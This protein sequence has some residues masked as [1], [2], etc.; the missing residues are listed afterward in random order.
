MISHNLCIDL[1]KRESKRGEINGE[2][3]QPTVAK[4]PIKEILAAERWERI[5]HLLGHVSD[6]QKTVLLL[7]FQEGQSYKEIAKIT[8]QSMSNVGML[9]HR[10]LK[11]LRTVMDE[12]NV[13][14]F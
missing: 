2:F 4:L 6:D 13:T 9:L 7:F 10:G 12:E 11:K 5:E 3:E 14:E 1:I 8:G